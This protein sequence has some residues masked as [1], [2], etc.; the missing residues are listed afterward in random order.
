MPASHPR[1]YV[2]DTSVLLSDP[3]CLTKFAE[4]HVILPLAVISEL[5]A[6]RQHPELGWFA[7]EALRHLEELRA[8]YERLDEPV[9]ANDEGGTLCVELNTRINP[10]CRWPCAGRAATSAFW[11]ARSTS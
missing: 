8:T 9:P 10:C 5:E 6:K 1:T 3:F 7:R 4:H 11:P 2:I